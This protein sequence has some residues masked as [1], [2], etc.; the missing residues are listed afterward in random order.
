MSHLFS[1]VFKRVY[2]LPIQ[3]Y[4]IEILTSLLNLMCR[5]S[6][7]FQ[8]HG[9]TRVC[10]YTLVVQMENHFFH[11]FLLDALLLY[12]ILLLLKTVESYRVYGLYI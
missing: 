11:F 4:C 1:F 7:L 6:K 2:K 9:C 10:I 12:S 8:L 5:C 3:L